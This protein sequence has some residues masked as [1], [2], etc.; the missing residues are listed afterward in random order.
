MK[1]KWKITIEN[2]YGKCDATEIYQQ[3]IFNGTM[4][5]A[6]EDAKETLEEFFTDG[7]IND[8]RPDYF[9]AF[10]SVHGD[11][12]EPD[13]RCLTIEIYKPKVKYLVTDTCNLRKVLFDDEK[14]ANEYLE[15]IAWGQGLVKAT[16]YYTDYKQY[17]EEN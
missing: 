14:S 11:W 8:D 10:Y 6:K 7:Y 12:D 2:S 3:W 4:E 17:L 15:T 13:E 9:N 1:N 5:E 16:E